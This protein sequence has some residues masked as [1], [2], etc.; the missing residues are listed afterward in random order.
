MQYLIGVDGQDVR[1]CEERGQARKDFDG[2]R[3][4]ALGN[5]EKF[6]ELSSLPLRLFLD[7][8]RSVRLLRNFGSRSI[9]VLSDRYGRVFG[10]GRFVGEFFA[11]FVFTHG[12]HLLSNYIKIIHNSTRYCKRLRAPSDNISSVRRG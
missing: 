5:A 11:L 7:R 10:R 2:E 6:I 3:R 1:H 12:K 4:P 9:C 8:G